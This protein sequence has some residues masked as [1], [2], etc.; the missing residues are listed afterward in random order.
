MD[1]TLKK[2]FRPHMNAVIPFHKK[3]ES[4][5]P[6]FFK[7]KSHHQSITRTHKHPSLHSIHS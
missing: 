2:P 4:K 6:F 3:I 7:S 5:I 1:T